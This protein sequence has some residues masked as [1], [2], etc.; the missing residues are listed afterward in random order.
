MKLFNKIAIVGVGLIGG[1]IGL[2]V[3]KK[4]LANSVIGIFRKKTS[5]K[6]ALDNGAIDTGALDIKAIEDADLIIL[7]TPVKTIINSLPKVFQ[8]AK[9]GAIIIDAGS[10][11]S[12]IINCAKKFLH[13]NIRFVGCHPLTGLEKKG[14]K[15]ADSNLFKNSLCILVPVDRVDDKIILFW[16]Q[17]GARVKILDAQRHD[18]IL[19]LVSH[20]PHLMAFNL[21]KV[22]PKE[23]ISF[24]AGGLR[25]TTRIASS[26]SLLWSDIF[27]TNRSAILN[28][29]QKFT[30]SLNQFKKA[31]KNNDSKALFRLIDE[32]HNKRLLLK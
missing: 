29:L 6:K 7:T 31:I 4:R 26:D 13:K 32:S 28:A 25:D 17:L 2:C 30:L 10:T 18:K 21:I 16:K 23:L 9:K 3:K 11:K 27:L 24:G 5:L 20:L 22:I 15:F 1:S 12:E 14:V 8:Y 19:S